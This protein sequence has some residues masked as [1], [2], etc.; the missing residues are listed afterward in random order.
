VCYQGK[1][2]MVRDDG[3]ASCLDLETGRLHWRKRLSGGTYRASVS[4]GDGKV[5]FLNLDGL[6]T[7]VASGPAE[8]TIA[9]NQLPG[10]FYAT[11][12]ISEGL[13]YLRAYERLY[14]VGR[15]RPIDH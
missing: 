2:Y 14:A 4:A 5:Y 6:C 3:I 9:Q 7:V 10:T 1:V 13:L 15:N 11:P 12:A 8:E